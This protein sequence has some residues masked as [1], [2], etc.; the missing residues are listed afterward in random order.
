[1]DATRERFWQT[2][3]YYDDVVW[4]VMRT[5]PWPSRDECEWFA[6]SRARYMEGA[7]QPFASVTVTYINQISNLPSSCGVGMGSVLTHR[8]LRI[9]NQ[10]P[11]VYKHR[12]PSGPWVFIPDVTWPTRVITWVIIVCATI[13]RHSIQVR[14]LISI[15]KSVDTSCPMRCTLK[16]T[17]WGVHDTQQTEILVTPVPDSEQTIQELGRDQTQTKHSHTPLNITMYLRV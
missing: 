14:V 5:I 10:R 6:L 9:S 16:M 4:K 2:A 13:V 1:M 3:H 15:C 11:S 17:A 12:R 7:D 8:P